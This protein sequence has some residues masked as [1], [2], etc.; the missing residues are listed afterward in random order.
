MLLRSRKISSE[1]FDPEAQLQHVDLSELT[2]RS[3]AHAS[4][5][6]KAKLPPTILFGEH[7]QNPG[8]TI[9]PLSEVERY[10]A[11]EP[12]A[13]DTGLGGLLSAGLQA[14]PALLVEEG[15]RGKQLMEVV[16]N[17]DLV[18]A[19]DGLGMRAWAVGTDGKI[20]EHAKLFDSNNLQNVVNAA[21]LW[22]IASVVV[23]QKHL[24]DISAKLDD[25]RKGVEYISHFLNEERRAKVTGTYEYLEQV[26]YAIGMGELSQATRT[27]LESCDHELLQIQHHLQHELQRRCMEPISHTEFA[28]TADLEKKT[29][30]KYEKLNDLAKDIRLTLKTRAL[31][32]HVL[33]LYPG[34]PSLKKARLEG[35]L[36]SASEVDKSLEAI[37]T[38]VKRDSD[39]FKSFWNSEEKL[40]DRKSN[41]RNVSKTLLNNLRGSANQLRE[42]MQISQTAML[43]NDKPTH[44]IF[45]IEDGRITE[46]KLAQ[47]IYKKH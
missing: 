34:E 22:Q 10:A 33:S 45:E 35:L 24:A 11:A 8:I 9:R 1:P 36:R 27:K 43:T 44:I 6:G 46:F 41:V 4:E 20:S 7:S 40:A 23:A 38:S 3:I 13:T 15:H 29:V 5:T 25:I 31:A 21:A 19:K 14:V 18:R 47:P 37:G 39:K 2:T 26:T 28:G 30:A 12:L 17:G 16:I 32:W 42:E